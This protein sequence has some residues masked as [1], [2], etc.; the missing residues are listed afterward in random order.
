MDGFKKRLRASIQFRLSV[1]LSLSILAIALAA[2]ASSFVSAFDEAHELQDDTLRQIAALLEQSRLK[3]TGL[4]DKAH[5][6]E[7]DEESRVIV[8]WLSNS[9]P[10]VSALH[11]APLPLPVAL[12]DGFHTLGIDHESY[13]VLVRSMAQGGRIA[14]SQETGMRDEIARD[15]ALRTLLPFLVLVPVLLVVV[16]VL[17]RTVFHPVT[18]LSA[19]IDRRADTA[20]PP[21]D[22]DRLPTEIRPFVLAI[23]RLLQRV[24]DAMAQQRRF[25]ADA[26]HELRS[27]LTALSL[28][29]GRLA[30]AEMSPDARDR[31]AN[32]QQGIER[33]RK[34]LDQLLMLARV[35]SD[36]VDAAGEVSA[37]QVFRQVLE[38]LMPLALDKHIDLGVAGGQD[39]LL[40]VH[41]QDLTTL[42]KNL[43]DNAIRYT[44]AGGTVDL[45]ILLKPGLAVLQV[46]DN[47]PGIPPAE[48]ERV[49]DP[50]YRVLGNDQ[51]GSG[52]GLSIV[53]AMAERMG[54]TVELDW[55]D[56]T[57]KLGLTVS[58]AI[59]LGKTPPSDDAISTG[60]RSTET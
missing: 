4:P 59:P 27:P 46:G 9:P 11:G 41:A 29:A 26:A 35:Q 30:D 58:V 43:V 40:P 53:R 47:G 34:L 52:L 17:I 28:Q 10:A 44:P 45:A 57:A 36:T 20:L 54:A 19:E 18:R 15:S 6:N 37:M 7:S 23:H 31:L 24:A 39:V 14:V 60:Y 42:V 32:L 22:E 8:Q 5:A 33:G 25:V 56:V 12:A 51:F 16:G 1:W 50:F 55:T 49:F 2:G 21:V 13:R 3:M 38:D 48:R